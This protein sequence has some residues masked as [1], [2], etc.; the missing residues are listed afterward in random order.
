M[1]NHRRIIGG[2]VN[3][4]NPYGDMTALITVNEIRCA[5]QAG[6][7]AF[8]ETCVEWHKFQLRDNMQNIFTKAFGA[9]R[10]EYSTPACWALGQ[11]VYH[12]VDSGRDETGCCRWSYLTYAAKEGT[13]IA[14]VSV[15]RSSKQTNHG[16]LTYW[17]QQFGIMYEDEELC[18]FLV[19]HQ[20]QTLV[21]LQYFM[22]ELK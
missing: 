12:I 9:A 10:L 5:L 20:K 2:N 14:I 19:D 8:S 6:T 16:D 18:P 1:E 7:I 4:L 22:E 3:G 13:K 17:K 15:Y 11:M 21:E